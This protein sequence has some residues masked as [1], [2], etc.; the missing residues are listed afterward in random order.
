MLLY[1]LMALQ[2]LRCLR[3]PNESNSTERDGLWRMADQAN[4]TRTIFCPHG[5]PD[6]GSTLLLSNESTVASHAVFSS[7]PV[8]GGN[9]T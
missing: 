2:S 9:R 7:S 6:A 4:G 5:E 8:F 3:G 1:R